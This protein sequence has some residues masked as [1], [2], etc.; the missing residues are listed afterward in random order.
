M[1]GTSPSPPTTTGRLAAIVVSHA[2]RK[3][4]KHGVQVIETN[5]RELVLQVHDVGINGRPSDAPLVFSLEVEHRPGLARGRSKHV[6]LITNHPPPANLIAGGA[7]GILVLALLLVVVVVR[8]ERG[9][10]CNNNALLGKDG[11][12]TRAVTAVVGV[13]ESGILELALGL[14]DPLTYERHVAHDESTTRKDAAPR[15]GG[16][17]GFLDNLSPTGG[18]RWLLRR[19]WPFVPVHLG[20]RLWKI[21]RRILQH[22]GERDDGFAQSHLLT[23]KAASSRR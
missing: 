20:S 13:D 9:V 2:A 21:W 8:S 16:P 11:C 10:G 17:S 5:K 18:R 3:Q 4:A 7:I 1:S 22:H 12:I 14:V 19:R 23:D 15:R 6:T